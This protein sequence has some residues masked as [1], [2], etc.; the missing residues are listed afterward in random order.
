MNAEKSE[1]RHFQCA[2]HLISYSFTLIITE[3][4]LVGHLVASKCHCNFLSNEKNKAYKYNIYWTNYHFLYFVIQIKKKKK[5]L[6]HVSGS[7][8]SVITQ[9]HKM[10]SVKI[11]SQTFAIITTHAEGHVR[12]YQDM[13]FKSVIFTVIDILCLWQWIVQFIC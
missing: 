12:Y 11:Q 2:D 10:Y 1:R 7:S 5:T 6:Q 3:E 4:G 9:S 8:L 13:M